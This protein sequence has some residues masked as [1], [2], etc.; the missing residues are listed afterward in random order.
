MCILV[1]SVFLIVLLARK[2]IREKKLIAEMK[3][4]GLANFEEGNPERI[5]ANGYIDEQADLLP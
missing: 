1:L 4:A 5:D 3:A 2:V